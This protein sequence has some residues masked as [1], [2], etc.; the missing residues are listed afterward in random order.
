M[1]E[2]VEHREF[3]TEAVVSAITGRLICEIGAVYEVLSYLHGRSLYTHELPEAMRAA[4][5]CAA[6]PAWLAALDHAHVTRDNWQA[7]RGALI[8]AH[9]PTVSLTPIKWSALAERSP[10]ETAVEMFGEDRVIVAEVRDDA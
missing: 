10:I 6:L 5:R 9:G 1:R 3:A 2:T 7:W 8:A 4:L